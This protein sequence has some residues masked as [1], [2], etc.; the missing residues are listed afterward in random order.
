[1]I[2]RIV[3]RLNGMKGKH[4]GEEHPDAQYCGHCA[5]VSSLVIRIS[6]RHVSPYSTRR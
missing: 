4:H 1:L 5:E 6:V 3:V 2:D